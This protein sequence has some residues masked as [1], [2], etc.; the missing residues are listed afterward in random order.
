MPFSIG[1]YSGITNV[2]SH[3]YV[4]I[5]IDSYDSLPL[6]KTLLFHVIILI[7]SVFNKD[8]NKYYYNIFWEKGSSELS[9]NNDNEF[10]IDNKCCIN[11]EITFLKELMLIKQVH[12]KSVIFATIG[13]F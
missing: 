1:K 12:Q 8:K 13:I 5:K 4:K 11:I 7:K 10:F 9:K 6:E 2:I 3:I